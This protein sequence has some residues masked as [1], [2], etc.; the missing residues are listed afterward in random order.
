MKGLASIIFAGVLAGCALTSS[1][2]HETF[3]AAPS[4]ID[5]MIDSATIE[6]YILALPPFEQAASRSH[7]HRSRLDDF[8]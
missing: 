6:D 2:R 1:E 7:Y 5:R 3:V 4:P 8:T